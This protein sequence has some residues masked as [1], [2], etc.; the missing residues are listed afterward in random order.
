MKTILPLLVIFLLSVG[1]QMSFAQMTGDTLDEKEA[2]LELSDLQGRWLLSDI[3]YETTIHENPSDTS[4]RTRINEQPKLVEIQSSTIYV[5]DANGGRHIFGYVK[6]VGRQS[7][8]YH[9]RCCWND[10]KIFH[11]DS[12]SQD[13]IQFSQ[14]LVEA[15]P[16]YDPKEDYDAPYPRG[17][18][19]HGFTVISVNV[20][21]LEREK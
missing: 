18:K 2:V 8:E 20:V 14:K 21:R 15:I 9:R 12:V 19:R 3:I 10:N 4:K 5:I 7:V 16:A 11:V 13:T 1:G 6:I 17:D